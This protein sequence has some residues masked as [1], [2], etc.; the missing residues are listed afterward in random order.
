MAIGCQ[1]NS[2]LWTETG[3]NDKMTMPWYSSRLWTETGWNDKIICQGV[4]KFRHMCISNH[5]SCSITK[6]NIH[7]NRT[8][9]FIS[10][11]EQCIKL[12]DHH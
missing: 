3:C 4:V 5:P 7:N 11:N 6:S 1:E 2:L 12:S 8:E 9:H 10:N